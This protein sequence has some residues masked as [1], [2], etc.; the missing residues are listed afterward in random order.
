VADRTVNVA[1]NVTPGRDELT[2][3]LAA[4]GAEAK[5]TATA[6]DEVKQKAEAVGSS[7]PAP[8]AMQQP[9]APQPS[10]ALSESRRVEQMAVRS[11]GEF[12]H[13]EFADA[14]RQAQQEQDRQ[15]QRQRQ[16]AM[17]NRA[18]A[19]LAGGIPADA[20]TRV[21]GASGGPQ[22]IGSGLG[23]LGSAL[24]GGGGPFGEVL[25][26]FGEQP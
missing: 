25:S 3:A 26:G 10:A 6:L 20:I 17:A 7:R 24:G 13:D 4:Q 18:R 19:T 14:L 9:S 5:K 2:P 16:E 11:R 8:P 12:G 22:S 21:G 15:A 1:V 23:Q